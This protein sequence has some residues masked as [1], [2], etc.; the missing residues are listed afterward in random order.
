[1]ILRNARRNKEERWILHVKF[2]ATIKITMAFQVVV[3]KEI[4][5]QYALNG[6]APV[7]VFDI[8][9]PFHR[10]GFGDIFF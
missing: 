3:V 9:S 10:I 7:A 8:G 4:R 5:H 1:M 6:L 2:V